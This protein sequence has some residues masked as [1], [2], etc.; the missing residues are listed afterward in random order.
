MTSV[1]V[2]FKDEGLLVDAL[3]NMG[4]NPQVN[5]EAVE[6]KGYYQNEKK[7]KAHIVVSKSQ[8]GGYAGV[9][10][11]RIKE[12]GFKMHIDN[13]DHNKFGTGKLKQHYSEATVMKAVN[14]NAK[15]SFKNR[16]T[17][18]DGKIKIRLHTNF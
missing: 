7:K 5:E 4:Y 15:F 11:E 10:F 14:K 2:E 9:G 12:G 16:S 13:M 17:T 6:I 18:K 3:K 1:D 8:V